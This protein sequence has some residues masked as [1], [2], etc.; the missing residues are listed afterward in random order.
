[1]GYPPDPPLGG[2][3]HPDHHHAT[4][5]TTAWQAETIAC[6][7]QC[8]HANEKDRVRGGKTQG[9]IQNSVVARPYNSDAIVPTHRYLE[10]TS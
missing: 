10:V 4:V 3:Y 2:N 9:D 1:M 7:R 5:T 8:F 6:A